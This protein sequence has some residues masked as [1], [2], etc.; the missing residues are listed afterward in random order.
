MTT[1]PLPSDT[2]TRQR[3]IE[4]AGE[5]F[6]D[7]GFRSATIRDI[8][9]RAGA[10]VAAVNYHFG[11]KERL[12]LDV[13]E[14][15]HRT[16]L[17][18]YPPDLGLMPDSSA[19]DRL[20][21][22]VR[23][24]L[25]R[26][27]DDGVPAWLGKLMAREM[28]EPTPALDGLVERVMRPLFRRLVGIVEDLAGE[29]ADPERV[30]LCA[31]SIVGQCVFYRHAQACLL[32]LGPAAVC[33]PEKAEAIADHVARFSLAAIRD[34]A[35]EQAPEIRRDRGPEQVKALRGK[36]GGKR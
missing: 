30:R 35:Q 27:L 20:R 9:S 13:L 6:A 31:Q 16:S 25:L 24:F 28:I 33:G 10:N 2:A 17:S 21:A 32:R 26:L 14:H 4:V 36:S 15:A 34:L 3:L 5:V 11:D 23:S 8:C 12:Y 29:G 22:F 19:E 1:A 7:Q 18:R